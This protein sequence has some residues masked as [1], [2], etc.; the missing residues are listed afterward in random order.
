MKNKVINNGIPINTT[1]WPGINER[2]ITN[3]TPKNW[4]ITPD[5]NPNVTEL[6][7]NP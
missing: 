4:P 5:K 7:E 6:I 3:A 1:F 2:A